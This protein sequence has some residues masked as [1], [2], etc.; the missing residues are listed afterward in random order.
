VLDIQAYKYCVHASLQGI[1]GRQ[2]RIGCQ[3]GSC[4]KLGFVRLVGHAETER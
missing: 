2:D 3:C 4:Y 1:A